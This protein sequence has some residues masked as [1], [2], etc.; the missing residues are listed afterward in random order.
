MTYY[1]LVDAWTAYQEKRY[2]QAATIWKALIAQAADTATRHDHQLG[3]AYV[4]IAQQNFDAARELLM[5]LNQEQP[6]TPAYLHQLALLESEAGQWSAA[7]DYLTQEMACLEAG[8]DLGLAQN[9]YQQGLVALQQADYSQAQE[10]A[11]QSKKAAE[12]A[13]S[14]TAVGQAWRLNGDI[15][16]ANGQK[17]AA[18]MAYDSAQAAFADEHNLSAIE[19]IKD[20]LE[21][22][23]A[24]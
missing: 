2:D 11:D 5:G 12:R 3:Y 24:E 9:Q 18:R 8:D 17:E 23:S 20:R 10:A 4:L 19:E 1:T 14:Q 22:I 16:L 6:R 13:Q 7:Q 15:A 21:K